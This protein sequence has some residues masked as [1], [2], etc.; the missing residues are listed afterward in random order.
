MP[1]IV[2]VAGAALAVLLALMGSALPAVRGLR[3]QVAQALADR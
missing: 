2:I 3:L 1:A